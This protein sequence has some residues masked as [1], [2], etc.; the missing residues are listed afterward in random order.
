MRLH[1]LLDYVYHNRNKVFC[2]ME[3]AVIET[4]VTCT[5]ISHG[6]ENVKVV[7]RTLCRTSANKLR[8][9]FSKLRQSKRAE[10]LLP[11]TV[12]VPTLCKEGVKLTL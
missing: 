5:C 2:D 4:S 1:T 10:I 6:R 12:P 3:Y 8:F 11:L 9:Y 7:I